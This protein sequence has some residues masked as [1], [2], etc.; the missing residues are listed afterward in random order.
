M[1]AAEAAPALV[2][3][4]SG[5]IGGAVAA[6]LAAAGHPVRCLLRRSSGAPAA[7]HPLI[8][9]VRADLADRS[10][11]ANALRN[12]HLVFH[13]AGYLHAGAPFSAREDYAPYRAANVELT[14]RMLAASA[15]AGVR[16]F[17]FTSTT[18]VYRPG[19]ASPISVEG[20]LA[21]L[22]AYG[23]SKV[24]AEAAVR[25]YGARGLS[26]T[27]VR[28]S[29]TYGPGDRHF[30][31]A[32]LAM[33]RMRR[34]PLV[35]GGRHL[36]DFGYVSDVARL[37]VQAAAAPAAAGAT[38]NAASGNPQPL[39]A[40]FDVHAELTGRAPPAILAV[41]AGLCRGL[42]P[43]LPVA[44][45]LFAPGM[46]ALVTRDALAYLSRDVYYDMSGAYDDFGYRPAIDFRAGLALVLASGG[47]D[48]TAPA[49]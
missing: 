15:E 27:I 35:D 25:D 19:V 47:L 42:G 36:V 29:A 6:Q 2:T 34:V 16:R 21:P 7:R 24:E 18:G 41:P 26:F 28:P 38:Y 8:E 46:S 11:L 48:A 44:T 20:A 30:L 49:S 4:A 10:A 31:P 39:R 40:L 9:V 13:V 17:V 22:S 5:M 14:Q 33:A 1:T 3:G 45:R 32:A 12:V 43:L 23:R 37:M